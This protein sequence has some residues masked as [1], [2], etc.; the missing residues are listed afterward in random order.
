MAKDS[1]HQPW[2][3]IALARI[4]N[5]AECDLEFV[6]IVAAALIDTRRLA[7]RSDEHAGKEVRQRRMI[8]PIAKDAAEEIGATQKRTV[9]G[10][11][12]AEREVIAAAG[13]GMAPIEHELLGPEPAL[14]RIV[15]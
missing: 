10:R 11:R 8:Q 5:L 4:G 2:R 15:I 12:T 6:K 7:G 1:V 9:R 3:T 14:M 13:A